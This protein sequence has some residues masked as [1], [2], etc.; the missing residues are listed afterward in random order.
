M[1]EHLP[2]KVIWHPELCVS[3]SG[4]SK[5]NPSINSYL[6]LKTCSTARSKEIT[7]KIAEM[8]A[9]DQSS[10]WQRFQEFHVVRWAWLYCTF[11][12]AHF[13][14]MSPTEKDRLTTVISNCG[15]VGLTTDIW[16]LHDCYCAF[17]Q[18][19]V[20]AVEQC[21]CKR[22]NAWASYRSS[23]LLMIGLC[24]PVG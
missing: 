13:Y 4:T 22:R 14:P 1:V 8:V 10:S 21:V 16:C 19:F 17:Y 2:W 12:H 3:S 20:A 5:Y 24:S 6:I 18:R 23:R 9:R 11:G 7:R 15:Y